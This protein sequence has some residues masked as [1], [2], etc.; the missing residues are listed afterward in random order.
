MI[1]IEVFDNNQSNWNEI[2][3][4]ILSLEVEAF[5]QHPF[6]DDELE[7]DFLDPEN[8]IVFLITNLNISL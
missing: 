3:E 5:E 7:Q 4:T 8:I 2:K 6:T 1:S